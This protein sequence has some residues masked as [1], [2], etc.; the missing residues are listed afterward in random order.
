MI[1][2][3]LDLGKKANEMTDEEVDAINAHAV[4]HLNRVLKRLDKGT[5]S[6]EEF[7]GR[8]YS[9]MVAAEAL[10]WNVSRMCLEAVYQG[11]ALKDKARDAD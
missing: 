3:S 7:L 5:L 6:K 4:K 9:Y 2:V 10:G 11:Q 1:G 8:C